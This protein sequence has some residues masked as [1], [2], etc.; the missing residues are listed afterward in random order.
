MN[1]DDAE[2]GEANEGKI[3]GGTNDNDDDK[4]E[5]SQGDLSIALICNFFLF[6]VPQGCHKLNTFNQT[7]LILHSR[8]SLQFAKT[9]RKSRFFIG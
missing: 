7:V 6:S 3:D 4:K 8:Y 1:E 5:G 2:E 9:L